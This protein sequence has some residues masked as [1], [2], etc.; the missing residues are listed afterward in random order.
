M[1]RYIF[2]SAIKPIRLIGWLATIVLSF[3]FLNPFIG[4]GGTI[5][6]IIII[7][8]DCNRSEFRRSINLQYRIAALGYHW[9]REAKE[10][11]KEVETVKAIFRRSPGHLRHDAISLEV[12]LDSALGDGLSLIESADQIEA[13]MKVQGENKALQ[14][15][16]GSVS[17]EIEKF[18][19]GVENASAKAILAF[20]RPITSSEEAL[21]PLKSD[22]ESL[23]KGLE[24]ANISL[25]ASLD[26]EGTLDKEFKKL[27]KKE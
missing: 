21:A 5:G 25:K 10:L 17:T 22:I 13:I 2:A 24:Q 9:R 27:E 11:Q 8:I 16:L 1:L 26:T 20:S 7:V 18:K 14:S 19:K 3:I 15:A 12:S 23:S 6:Y 4:I